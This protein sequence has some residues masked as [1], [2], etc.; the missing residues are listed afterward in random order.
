M[1][2]LWPISIHM[3]ICIWTSAIPQA[4]ITARP[5]DEF[6]GKIKQAV[7]MGETK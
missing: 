3:A 7:K 5:N 1:H 4:G 2:I 6:L